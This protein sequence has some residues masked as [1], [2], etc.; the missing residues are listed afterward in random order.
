VLEY[1]DVSYRWQ[2]GVKTGTDLPVGEL[3]DWHAMRDGMSRGLRGYDL[4]GV[5]VSR[6][7][8]YKSKFDPDLVRYYNVRRI[9][10]G[11]RAAHIGRRLVRRL[12]A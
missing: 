1:R 9:S 12:R 10:K 6:L 2:G 4:V 3:L 11:A 7:C 5:N 8:S